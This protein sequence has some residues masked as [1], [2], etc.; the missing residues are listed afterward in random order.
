[1]LFAARN[2]ILLKIGVPYLQYMVKCIFF[3]ALLQNPLD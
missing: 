3:T 1:M 2:Q